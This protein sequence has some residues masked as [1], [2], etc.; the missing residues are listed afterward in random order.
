MQK[1]VKQ[2]SELDFNR[3]MEKT[4]GERWDYVYEY[5]CKTGPDPRGYDFWSPRVY[6]ENG[7]YYI[8]W[9]CYDSCD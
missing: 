3:L 8:S 4:Q 9:Q 7:V 1:I 5:A 2:I 6:S